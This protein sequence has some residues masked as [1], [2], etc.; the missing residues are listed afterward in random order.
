MGE[1]SAHCLKCSS[2]TIE[3]KFF[4]LVHVVLDHMNIYQQLLSATRSQISLL[5]NSKKPHHIEP[6]LLCLT[7]HHYSRQL[8]SKT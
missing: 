8:A 4:N 6:G 1:I 2:L 3:V 7:L 5:C